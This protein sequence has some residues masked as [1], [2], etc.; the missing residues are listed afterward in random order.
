MPKNFGLT[1]ILI[2]AAVVIVLFGAK[3]IPEFLKGIGLAIKEFK[4]A[5]KE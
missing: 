4:K 5:Q 2:I 3:K 1:E